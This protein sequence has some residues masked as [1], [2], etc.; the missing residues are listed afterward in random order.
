MKR[1][2]EFKLEDG[3]TSIF[4]SDEPVT[5]GTTR[6]S[7]HP[8][9]IAEEAKETFEMALSKICQ[10]TEKVITTLRGL[11]NWPD[12]IKR[13]FG[14]SLIAAARLVIDSASM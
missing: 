13:E 1:F 7:R 10:A 3:S 11:A 2:V 12:E 9:E 8:G 5:R 4:E 14:F 6:A